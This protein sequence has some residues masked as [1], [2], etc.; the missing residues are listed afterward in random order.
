MQEVSFCPAS[1]ICIIFDPDIFFFRGNLLFFTC[2]VCS[3]EIFANLA[4][5]LVFKDYRSTLSFSLLPSPPC[6]VRILM[7]TFFF[8]VYL[9][10]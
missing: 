1:D 4:G 3:L 8:S 5:T 6:W 9:Y 7:Y 10:L 2:A